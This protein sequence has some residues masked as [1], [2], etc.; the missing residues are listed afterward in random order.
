VVPVT[1]RYSPVGLLLVLTALIDVAAAVGVRRRRSSTG[2]LSLAVVLAAAGVWCGA[3]G[4]ELLAV[5]RDG[6]E[7]WGCLEYVGTTLLPPAWLIFV[8]E[9]TGRPER[10]TRRLL[11]LLAIEPLAVLLVLLMPWTRGS[12][13]H[14]GPGPPT[15]VP[16][17]EVGPIYWGHFVWTQGLILT[18]TAILVLRLVRISSLYRRQN[19]TLLGAVVF[20][21]L[22]NLASS[23]QLPLADLYDPTPVAVSAGTWILVWGVFRYRLLDLLPVAH[24]AAFDRLVD[25]ILVIDPYGRVVDRNPAAIRVLGAGADL[26]TPMQE[27]LQEHVARLDA[28]AEGAELKLDGPTGSIEFEMVMS[29]LDDHRGRRAGQLVQLRDITA[30]KDAERRL[31][32]LADFDQLTQLPNRRHLIQRLERAITRAR[33]EGGRCTL[34]VLDLDR[35][36]VINDTLGHPVG[37]RVLACVGQRLLLARP[38]GGTAAR[39]GGDEFAVVLPGVGLE[40]AAAAGRRV[41]AALADPMR[42]GEHEMIVTAS[43]GVA[44]WPDDGADGEELLRR[45][46][47]AMYRAKDHGRN[48]AEYSDPVVDAGSARRRELSVDLWHALRRDELYLQ[49]QPLVQLRTG[50]VSGVEALVRWRHPEFG[51]LPPSQFLPVAEEAGLMLD[52]DRWVL[53]EACRQAQEWARAGRPVPVN[54]NVSPEMLRPGRASLVGEV[55][56]ALET[57]G[58]PAG[59]LVIEINEQTVISDTDDVAAELH[60]VR[61]LGVRLA[62]DDFG[63]GHTSLTHLRRLPIE[64]LKIDQGLIA[65]VAEN[66]EDRRILTAVTALAQILDL[67]V[68]AEGIARVAQAEAVT[69]AGCHVGQG[70]L[71]STPVDAVYVTELL[72]LQSARRAPLVLPSGAGR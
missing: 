28:T 21:S 33:R 29:P 26:G 59:L 9:Y 58:L 14:F 66:G 5:G 57:A 30:R 45:A 23:L 53:N 10:V 17:I 55:T 7:F 34:L 60:R 19:A 49:Y 2:R 48:R 38:E 52:L 37:D 51:A 63:A 68:V 42:L 71:Y 67:T 12:F 20:G 3:Y 64:I 35:F 27:L 44:V 22:G 11:A 32:W 8:L 65:N 69:A 36:K 43:V 40:G 15:P 39:L 31:R 1:F 46:D 62:L 41:L 4:L 70:F 61:R 50:R 56:S 54:V 13:R 16:V 18:G 24:G 25:P 47:A 72:D 6:Q